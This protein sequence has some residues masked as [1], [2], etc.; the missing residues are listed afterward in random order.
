MAKPKIILYI[1]TSLDG[2][3][4]SKDLSVAWLDKYQK[5]DTDYGY[6]KFFNSIDGVVV[7]NTTQKQFPQNYERKPTFVF[8]RKKTE[9]KDNLTYVKG[10]VKNFMSK[11]SLKGNI[12]LL[13]GAEIIHQFLKEDLIDEFIIFVM[14]ELL[15]EGVKLFKESTLKK[16]LKLINSKSYGEVIELHYKK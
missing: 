8:S 13:G 3:I 2:F 7:G 11:H 14:P 10:T 5:K 15:G 4:A 6:K 16:K 1:A 12:W 9:A